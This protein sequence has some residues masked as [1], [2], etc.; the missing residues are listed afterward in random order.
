MR[1]G[2]KRRNYEG[3]QESGGRTFTVI[4]PL[5][6]EARVAEIARLIGGD[7][8]SEAAVRHAEELLQNAAAYKKSQS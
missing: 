6:G 2:T 8:E 3:K 4:R 5:E 7:A 1:D